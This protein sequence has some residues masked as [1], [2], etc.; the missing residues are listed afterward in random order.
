MLNQDALKSDIQQT[1]EETLPYAIAEAFKT[2]FNQE[3]SALK[4]L[5]K[6]LVKH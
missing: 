6:N 4:M 1:F 3:S 5:H 2:T